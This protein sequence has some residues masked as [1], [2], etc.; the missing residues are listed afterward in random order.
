MLSIT[1]QAIIDEVERRGW[2][3]E[4]FDERGI[5]YKVIDNH[6]RSAIG[7][8]GRF[9]FSSVN[10]VVVA[11]DKV[12]SYDFV[13]SLGYQ[14]LEYTLPADDIEAKQFLEKHK[15]VV[16]KPLDAEQSRGVTVDVTS[17]DVLRD[18]LSFARSES[19]SSGALLQRQIEGKLYRILIINNK[20]FAAAYRRAAYV[21][22]DGVSTVRELVI[23]KN[24]DPLRSSNYTTPLKTIDV[25][26]AQEF[27]GFSTF[28]SVLEKNQEIEV[29]SIPSVSM[30]GEAEDVT[31][32]VHESYVQASVAIANNLGLGICGVDIIT[33][34][35]STPR[36]DG[37]FPLIELNSLPGFKVHLYPTAGGKVRNP[38]PAVLDAAF[39]PL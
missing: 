2:R 24:Q 23:E 18:A 10:G 30:G 3:F 36:T 25:A 38:A 33:N 8:G 6:G 1:R 26:A 14:L 13:R 21:V 17:E 32:Q 11:N 31:D 39:P 35:I 9:L 22:G 20:L 16:V 34:D 5:C 29:S 12:M 27:V 15:R 7:R 28:D 4:L 37:L 19:R